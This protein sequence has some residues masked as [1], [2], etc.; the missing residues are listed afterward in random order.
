MKGA[1]ACLLSAAQFFSADQLKRPLYIVITADEEIGH[2][3]ARCVVDESKFYREMVETGT[4]GIVAEPTSLDVVYAH[5]GSFLI[6]A[7]ADG[8]A[9]HSASR[10]GRN[11]NLAMI[12]FLTEMKAIHDETEQDGR[13]QHDH[14]DPPTLSWNIGISDSNSAPNVT[15][16]KSVCTVYFRPMPHMNVEPLLD[17][18]RR[19]AREHGLHLDLEPWSKP[20]FLDPKS[21]FVTT[22]LQ[23]AHRP[24]AKT[25]PYAT[26]GGVFTELE[27]VIVFGPGS[28]AQAHT[29]DEWISIEQLS[30]A[31]ELFAK[32]IRH[33]CAE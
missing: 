23:L 15:A 1:I 26:D 22:A 27:N 10:Q 12:P 18:V 32:F 11:A 21:D 6:R 4:K 7:A 25:V 13:W 20:I 9:G 17:R 31:T 5:K 19:S 8:V 33:F 28:I 24:S 2:A 29:I 30:L 16:S 14:F 3:G